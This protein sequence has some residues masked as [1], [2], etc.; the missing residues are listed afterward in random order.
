[1]GTL[2]YVGT[3]GERLFLNEELN[4]GIN[5][6]RLNPARGSIGARTNVGDSIYHGLQVDLRRQFSH[7]FL[8]EVAY[9]YSKSID[10]GSEV[11]TNSGGSSYVQDPFNR[12]GDRGVSAFDRP[13]RAAI[14]WVYSLPYRGNDAGWRGVTN[15]LIRTW[16]IS[17]TAQ[18]QSGAPDTIYFGGL[19]ENGDLRTTND[20]PDV[21]NLGVPINLSDACLNSASCIS[22][23]GLVQSDGTY[24]DA[25]TGAV[26]T[27]NQFRYVSVSGR[28]GNLGRNTY[29]N[30]WTQDYTVAAE[31]IFPIPQTEHH[32]LEFR[33]EAINPAN[34]PNP[35]LVSTNLLD[36]TFFNKD[37]VYTGGRTL[38][39]WLKYRF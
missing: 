24:V 38:N 16:T 29:R 20:R 19:D 12:A 36:P 8:L 3:R 7:G 28:P 27:R 39:L 5:G 30:D 11:F 32:Q 25:N 14:T 10:D 31:R 22:G 2:A 34:H 9:T 35:G 23:I 17:G 37:L 1:L 15:Q 21:A 4:P 26:G 18:L 13:H 33:A 6:V